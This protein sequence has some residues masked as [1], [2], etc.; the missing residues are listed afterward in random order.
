MKRLAA[1]WPTDVAKLRDVLLQSADQRLRKILRL[2]RELV[3]ELRQPGPQR[4]IQGVP[5]VG[6]TLSQLDQLLPDGGDQKGAGQGQKDDESNAREDHTNGPGDT[7]PLQTGDKRV[8]EVGDPHRQKQR[9]KDGPE[10]DQNHQRA[11]QRR[12][13]DQQ[14]LGRDSGFRHSSWRPW[15][16]GG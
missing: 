15:R 3:G 10:D 1:K 4:S 2:S 12:G 7:S 14:T 9:P 13:E 8:E 5:V 16:L 6:E 11:D